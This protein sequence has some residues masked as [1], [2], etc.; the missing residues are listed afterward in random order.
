[1]AEGPCVICKTPWAEHKLA[2]A[3]GELHHVWSSDGSLK[4]AESPRPE[5][6][7]GQRVL[8]ANAVDAQLRDILIAKGVLSSEDFAAPRDT[9]D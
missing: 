4:H 1:M 2:E 7:T 6:Q 9:S 5:R 8:I 3:N